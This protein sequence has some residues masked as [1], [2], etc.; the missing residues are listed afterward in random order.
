MQYLG[1]IYH[2]CKSGKPVPKVTVHDTSDD[3]AY[4]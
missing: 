2:T 3:I 4:H 1:V